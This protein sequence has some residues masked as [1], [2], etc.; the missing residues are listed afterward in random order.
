MLNIHCDGVIIS[1]LS[2]I[3]ADRCCNFNNLS[4][5]PREHLPYMSY[6]MWCVHACFIYIF[7]RIFNRVI[8][9]VIFKHKASICLSHVRYLSINTPRSFCDSTILIT[10]LSRLIS[11]LSICIS[12]CL[13][14]SNIHTVFWRFLKG[15]ITFVRAHTANAVQPDSVVTSNVMQKCQRRISRLF[16]S[17]VSML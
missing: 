4:K 1:A 12:Y 9:R 16:V 5:V 8:L 15:N 10:S 7:D 2:M 6:N 17:G 14:S 11:N 3:L 13:E